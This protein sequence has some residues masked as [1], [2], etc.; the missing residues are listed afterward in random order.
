MI[1]TTRTDCT[2]DN[3]A[4]HLPNA[5][6][7]GFGQ[8]KAK[9]GNWVMYEIDD[10][11]FVGRVI[12]RVTCEGTVYVEVAQATLDFSSVHVR[13]IKP[14]DIRECRAN[15]PRTVFEFFADEH[16]NNDPEQV[17]AKLAYGVSDL[18]DQLEQGP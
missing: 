9:R 14:T 13:W 17:H 8:P 15:P 6:S 10:H 18:R 2:R 4:V 7:L 11:H 3:V 16:W 1:T 12:G 5:T